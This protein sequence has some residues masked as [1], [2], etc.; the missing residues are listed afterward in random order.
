TEDGNFTVLVSFPKT[1]NIKVSVFTLTGALISQN[2]LSNQSNY[3][4]KNNIATS[5]VY[6]V[7]INSD[8]DE[9]NYKLIVK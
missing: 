9:K 5:G 2:Y 6:L 8:F 7:K 4:L 3:T 1:T